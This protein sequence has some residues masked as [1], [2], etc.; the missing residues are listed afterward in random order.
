MIASGKPWRCINCKSAAGEEQTQCTKC[1][2]RLK[3]EER[4]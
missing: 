2:D 3:A 1:G 4:K